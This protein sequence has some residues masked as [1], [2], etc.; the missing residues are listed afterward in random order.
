LVEI[1]INIMEQRR[2]EFEKDWGRRLNYL[3]LNQDLQ[4]DDVWQCIMSLLED[5]RDN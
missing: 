4:F 5:I 1:D 2:I 3:V